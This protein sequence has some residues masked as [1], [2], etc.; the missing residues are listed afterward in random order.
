M[1]QL[2]TNLDMYGTIFEF[3]IF[4][5]SKFKTFTGGIF[6]LMSLTTILV[7]VYLFGKD[8]FLRENPSVLFHEMHPDNYP[9]PVNL[10][11]ENFT[12]AW[13]LSDDDGEPVNFTN[14]F[15]PIIEYRNYETNSSGTLLSKYLKL[16]NTKCSYDI[17]K[18]Q[19]LL[20]KI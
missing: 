2:I 11:K 12:I 3:T 6:T 14:L 7:F 15:Y 1:N 17:V 19:N 4:K 18:D 9:P 5:K 13:R 8:F 10:N 20:K 16:E